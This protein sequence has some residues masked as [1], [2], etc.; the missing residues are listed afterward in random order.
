MF[1]ETRCIRSVPNPHSVLNQ[2][3]VCYNVAFYTYISHQHSEQQR[4]KTGKKKISHSH[5][6]RNP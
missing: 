1:F 3:P 5:L 2:L 6:N 4:A